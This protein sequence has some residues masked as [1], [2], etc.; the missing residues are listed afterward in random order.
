M[1]DT[2]QVDRFAKR[3]ESKS[4]TIDTEAELWAERWGGEAADEMA[5]QAPK[6]TGKGARSIRQVEPGGIA[7]GEDYMYKY[8]DRGTV[9]MPPQPFI[10]PAV[11][12]V[13][14]R[15]VRDGLDRGVDI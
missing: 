3:L 9:H 15:A 6:D 8:V 7:I 5:Q 1:I 12:K 11:N 4:H 10:S 13:R 14:P 2:S